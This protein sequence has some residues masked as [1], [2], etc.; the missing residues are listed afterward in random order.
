MIPA[1][2]RKEKTIKNKTKT[3]CT[4]ILTCSPKG[5]MTSP[6]IRACLSAFSTSGMFRPNTDALPWDVSEHFLREL[7]ENGR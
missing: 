1:R 5:P 4:V 6:F 3:K 7:G 2:K